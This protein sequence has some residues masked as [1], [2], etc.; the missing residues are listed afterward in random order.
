MTNDFNS[1][2]SKKLSQIVETSESLFMRYGVKRVTV[3][4]ICQKA[5]VSKMTFYKY[6][7]NKIEL[8][9]YVW[10]SWFD[11]GYS[12]IEEINA[13]N[14][15]ITEKLPLMIEWKM[16]FLSE[17]SPE[18][19]DEY[20]NIDPELKEFMQEFMQRSYK[21]FLGYIIDWQKKG[22]IRPEI[23]PEF[24]IAVVDKLQELFGDDNLRKLYPADGELVLELHKLLFYGIV[25]RQDS[26]K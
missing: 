4:E 15:P 14:I 6:F 7:S 18:F 5:N 22:D 11:E 26:E 9:K 20:I 17:M 10:N 19:I 3:E 24:F 8:V 1:K 2:K 12:K 25:P 21:L 23:R 13:M 16:G